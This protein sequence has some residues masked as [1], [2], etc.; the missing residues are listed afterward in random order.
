MHPQID[1]AVM[2]HLVISV[3]HVIGIDD[4]AAV[5]AVADAVVWSG[6]AGMIV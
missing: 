5:G 1:A 2:K 3:H 6:W 4:V